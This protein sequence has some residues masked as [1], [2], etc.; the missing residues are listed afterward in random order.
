MA[1]HSDVSRWRGKALSPWAKLL[2]MIYFLMLVFTFNWF[3]SAKSF[4]TVSQQGIST[5]VGVTCMCVTC[6]ACVQYAALGG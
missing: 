5:S 6:A 1:A 4:N 2:N 3:T